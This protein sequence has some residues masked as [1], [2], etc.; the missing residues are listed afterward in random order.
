MIYKQIV[1]HSEHCKVG[2]RFYTNR[3]NKFALVVLGFNFQNFVVVPINRMAKFNRMFT[4]RER[5][6]TLLSSFFTNLTLVLVTSIYLING[7]LRQRS[8]AIP[9]V[10]TVSRVA[11]VA[12]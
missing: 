7:T 5:A 12:N 1:C 8:I 2:K 4:E 3:F 10:S 11:S 9:R 6:V